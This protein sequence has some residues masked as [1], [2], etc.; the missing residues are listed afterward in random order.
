M[1]NTHR[2]TIL[3]AAAGM[4]AITGCTAPNG[5]SSSP[6]PASAPTAWEASIGIKN[7]GFEVPASVRP[8]A[9]IAVTNTDSAPHT[10]T[11]KDKGGFDVDVPAGATVIFEAP[12]EAGEYAITCTASKYAAG[13]AT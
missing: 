7:F 11:A 5:P 4:A 13:Y 1:R 10:L 6:A 12:D 2:I 9:M 8:G 3:A